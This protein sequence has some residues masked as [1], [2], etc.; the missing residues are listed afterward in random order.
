MQCR[1]LAARAEW[2]GPNCH[3]LPVFG[4]WPLQRIL[5]NM[6]AL[7]PMPHLFLNQTSL[8]AQPKEQVH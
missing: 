4:P 3:P 5:L 1:I 8:V 2:L 6:A 7:Q